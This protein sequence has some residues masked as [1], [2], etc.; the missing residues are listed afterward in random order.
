MNKK[1]IFIILAAVLIVVIIVL[2][3]IFQDNELDITSK[4][5]T[6]LHNSLGEANINKC[7]GLITYSDKAITEKDLESDN[8]LCMAYYRLEKDQKAENT[9]KSSGKNESKIEICQ[10]GESTT[11][12]TNNDDET[13]CTYETIN[14]VDLKDA[15]QKLYGNN[16]PEVESFY[17]SDKKA[18]FK[19]GEKYYCGD[20]ETYNLSLAPETTIYRIIKSAVE[21]SNGDIIIY[22]Y[23][24]KVSNTTCYSKNNNEENNECS[25][26]LKD[27]DLTKDKEVISLVKKY[28]SVYKHTFKKDKNENYY[29]FKSELS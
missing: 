6:D 13:E 26:N 18:C 15:Y 22:D 5:V 10:V 20:S 17:I 2:G 24:L 14:E 4:K 29:W 11:L 23:F 3:I 8:R 16:L 1:N 9:I 19:E 12:A 25:N 21:K 27:T 7:G 28:G